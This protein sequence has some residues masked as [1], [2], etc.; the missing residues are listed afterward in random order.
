M[1]H[2][3]FDLATMYQPFKKKKTAAELV[4]VWQSLNNG[5]HAGIISSWRRVFPVCECQVKDRKPSGD[6]QCS[7][8]MKTLN[9]EAVINQERRKG[10]I[11]IVID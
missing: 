11:F 6:T 7:A 3:F 9:R 1:Q 2:A 5:M 4:L 10:F 8:G